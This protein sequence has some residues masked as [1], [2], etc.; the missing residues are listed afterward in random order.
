MT[1]LNVVAIDGPAGSGKSTVARLVADRLGLTHIDTGA[2]YRALT[3]K[4]LRAG[5]SVTDE[6]AIAGAVAHV[7][8]EFQG[9]DILLDGEVVTEEIR[10]AKVTKHVSPLSAY[11]VVR[12]ALLARQRSFAEN[13][14]S[15]V[16][17]GRD[18]GTV[19]FPEARWKFFLDAKPE[20]RAER[21]YRELVAAGRNPDPRK[22][23]F[24]IIERDRRDSERITAPLKPAAEAVI[25]D[26]SQLS[27]EQVVSRIAKAVQTPAR[28]S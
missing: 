15:I 18:I 22:V 14:S 28:A 8:I 9:K 20:V 2:M 13:G 24:D 17:E 11:P 27:I 5:I 26:T 23:L 6:T 16:M 4:V 25:V 19:V 3:I 7:D 1:A 21:R 12:R 10:S